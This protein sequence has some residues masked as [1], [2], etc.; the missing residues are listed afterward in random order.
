MSKAMFQG[1]AFLGLF[2][3]FI[4][5]YIGLFSSRSISS[6]ALYGSLFRFHVWICG[7]TFAEQCDKIQPL[8]IFVAGLHIHWSFSIH[9]NLDIN[10]HILICVATSTQQRNKVPPTPR[11][12]RE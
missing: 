3:R 9:E 12:F 5:T 10:R 7:K 4:L 2:C 8:Q 6:V 1:S 11:G